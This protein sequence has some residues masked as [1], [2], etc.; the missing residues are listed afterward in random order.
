MLFFHHRA[1][2]S[3]N[4]QVCATSNQMEERQAA[5]NNVTTA[6]G[7]PDKLAETVTQLGTAVT[8]WTDNLQLPVQ[9]SHAISTRLAEGGP[10]PSERYFETVTAPLLEAFSGQGSVMLRYEYVL[11]HP[12]C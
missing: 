4:A 12:P 9:V 5:W 2:H 6:L 10:L 7:T 3:G 11:L 1:S 8:N